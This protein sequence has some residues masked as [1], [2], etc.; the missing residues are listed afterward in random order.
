MEKVELQAETRDVFGKKVNKGRKNGM[1]PAVAYG[2]GVD[3]QALWIK[4][5]D[6][7]RLLKSAGES[8]VIDLVIGGSDHRNVL[9]Y[10]MQ[11][12]PVSGNCTHVDFFQV[13]MDEEIETEVE[14]VFEGESAAIKEQGGMLVK[15][16]DA[17]TVKCLP[18]DLPSEIRIDISSLRTFDDRIEVKDLK[19]SDKVKIDL[20]PETVVASVAEPRSEEEL[21]QLEEKVE[22][23]VTKVEGVVKE[24]P[25]AEEKK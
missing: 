11:N 20:D 10:E 5:L 8:T 18:A 6:L 2:K 13:R 1:V 23:D 21:S 3:N 12:D 4:A 15:N 9:I 22:G 17:V 19:V 14:L 16:M 25:A 24:Q 7:S